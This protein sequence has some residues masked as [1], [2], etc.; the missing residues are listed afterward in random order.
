MKTLD[1]NPRVA[2]YLGLLFAAIPLT[3]IL[4]FG[5]GVAWLLAAVPWGGT[6]IFLSVTT[7]L[8]G[9]NRARRKRDRR[10]RSRTRSSDAVS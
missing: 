5:T 6:L 3:A 9:E 10:D 4:I 1:R 7:W 8:E 2:I